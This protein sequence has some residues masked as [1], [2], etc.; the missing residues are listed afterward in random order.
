MKKGITVSLTSIVSFVIGFIFGGKVLVKV[1]ND[2]KKRM[3][4]NLT[5]MLLFNDWLEFLYFG[6]KIEQYFYDHGYKRIMIYGNGYIGKRL[7]QALAQTDIEIIAIMDKA[8]LPN[9]EGLVIGVDS[10]IPDVDCIIVTPVY[11][12]EEIYDVIRI[13]INVPIISI[14]ELLKNEALGE[15]NV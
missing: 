11:Y 10:E 6:G 5:N 9:E 14:K 7:Q 13:K 1:V 2:Y 8:V 4:R 15:K 3:E 12:L